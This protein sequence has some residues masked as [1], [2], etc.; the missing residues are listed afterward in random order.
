MQGP[1]SPNL[2]EL[3]QVVDFLNKKLRAESQW[4]ITAEYPTALN[5]QNIHNMRIIS[6]GERVLSHAVLKPLIVKSPQVIFKVG[7]IGS[8]VTDPDHQ[9][10]GLSSSLIQ[11]CLDLAQK[12][13]CD[14]AILWTNLYDF[15]RRFGFEL[16]GTE[17]SVVFEENFPAPDSSL[18]Y[19]TDAKISPAAIHRLYSQHTVGS[20]RSPEDTKKYLSIPNTQVYTAWEPN[21][22]LAA[23]AIEGKGEDL[24][25]YIHEWGGNVS[26]LLSLLSF[27]R[28][29]KGQAFTMICPRHSLNLMKN[30]STAEVLINEGFL[31]MIK[32]VNFDQLAAKIKR[33]FRA[34]GVADFVLE[35]HPDHY[36]FG[37]G[38]EIFTLQNEQ[39]MV[40][41]LFGPVQYDSLQI[42]SA[43]AL[44][45]IQK[46]LPLK[47]WI[48]GWDSI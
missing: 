40:R 28:R 10:K 6:D 19:S 38:S 48:W 21:G 4:P 22:T 46:V 16:S 2:Q 31:G 18:R 7:A 23:Y 37:I 39:D 33:A 25:G 43:P 15:Y 36:V 1:R 3:P 8:V 27:I 9:G 34:E 30:L 20:I 47:M 29:N 5:L 14:I 42:F 12:Q 35:K 26:K 13:S 44:E 24:T 11:D 17:I 45:K 32:M 41:F